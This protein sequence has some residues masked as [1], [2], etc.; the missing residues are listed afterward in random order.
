MML[1]VYSI[2]GYVSGLLWVPGRYHGG[3]Y[4]TGD[5]VLPVF[6]SYIC[7]SAICFLWALP[8]KKVFLSN[9]E[10]LQHEGNAKALR[11]ALEKKFLLT[12]KIFSISV[13]LI[14][15]PFFL[16]TTFWFPK[17]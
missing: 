2:D 12:P 6:L 14:L 10:V 13:L 15:A 4:V 9:E 16:G 3:V 11:R 1:L 5:R 7:T 17:G 8:T